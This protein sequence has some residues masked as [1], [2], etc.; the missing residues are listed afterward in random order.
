MPPGRTGFVT[1]IRY[2]DQTTITRDMENAQVAVVVTRR[3]QT[4]P[5]RRTP[6]RYVALAGPGISCAMANSVPST[7]RA[8]DG[9]VGNHARTRPKNHR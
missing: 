4:G 9:L 6:T 7:V 1:G 5:Q 2:L 8:S 3:D